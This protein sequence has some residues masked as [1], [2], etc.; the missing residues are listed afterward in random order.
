MQRP[1]SSLLLVLGLAACGS[2]APPPDE[3]RARIAMDLVAVGDTAKASTADGASLPDTSQFSLIQSAFEGVLGNAEIVEVSSSISARMAPHMGLL[4]ADGDEADPFDGAA[5]AKWLDDNVFTDANHAGDGVYNVPPSIACDDGDLDCAQAFARLQL[6]IRVTSDDDIL[7]FALQLGPHHDEPLEVGLSAKLLSLTVDL[8][9]AEDAVR[10]LAPKGEPLPAFSL[11]GEATAKLEVLG[12]AA[13][14]VSFDIDRDIAV[15][16]EGSSITSK[17][18]HVFALTLDGDKHAMDLALGLGATHVGISDD[19]DGDSALDLGGLTGTL[20]YVEGQPLALSNISLGQTTSK[21]T[22][23]GQTA[24]ALDLNPADGRAFSAQ[25]GGD[26]LTVTPRIDFRA[27]VD[28]A[29]LGDI[30]PVYDVTRILLDGGLR[31]HADQS[32]EALGTF[33]IETNPASF[34]FH[35]SA[36]QC[37]RG[38]ETAD[39]Q[40]GAYYTQFTVGA[41]N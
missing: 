14:R 4:P 2:D 30:A 11:K 3:V 40:T 24:L 22:R 13:A 29:A 37:V 18:A 38:E 6:R 17:K 7:R 32:V 16:F 28:H 15:S 33:S 36:G 12:A 35:A 19:I 23:D 34:G 21:I 5:A 8:D 20:A 10:A 31:A 1:S 27:Q 26:T 9:E 41:C 25:L 39:A